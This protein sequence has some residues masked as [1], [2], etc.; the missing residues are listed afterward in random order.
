MGWK[1]GLNHTS[2]WSIFTCPLE[3]QT[4]LKQQ[5]IWDKP[6]QISVSFTSVSRMK[7]YQFLTVVINVSFPLFYLNP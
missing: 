4:F 3:T 1:H 6:T 2:G 5:D 7:Y